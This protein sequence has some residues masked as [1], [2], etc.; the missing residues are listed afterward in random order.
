MAKNAVTIEWMDGHRYPR[1]APDPRYPRG[2]DV[3]LASPE[4]KLTCTVDLPCPAKRCG[5]YRL[6][7]QICDQRIALTTAGRP[8]DPRSVRIPCRLLPGLPH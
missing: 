2:M 8:D 5:L 6:R 3:D 1:E 7:C 4:D